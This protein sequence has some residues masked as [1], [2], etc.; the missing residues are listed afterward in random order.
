M[1]IIITDKFQLRQ[2]NFLDDR[3]GIAS[4]VSA[5]KSWNY[6]TVP[7]PE[8]FEVYVGGV[9][10]VYRSSHTDDPVTGKFRTRTDSDGVDDLK[11]RVTRL[12]FEDGRDVASTFAQIKTEAFWTDSTGV[13]HA[14]AGRIVTVT[15]DGAN[16]GPWYLVASDYTK[17]ENWIKLIGRGDLVT[18]TGGA[19]VSNTSVYTSSKIDATFPKKASSENITAKWTFKEDQ[20]FE[21]DLTT[22]TLHATT[23]TITN[24]SSTTGNISGLT[25]GTANITNGTVTTLKSTTGTITNLNSTT[26]KIT[27]LTSETANIGTGTVTT[28]NSTTGTIT[29]LNSTAGNISNLTSGTANIGTGTITALTSTNSTTASQTVTEGLR[30]NNLQATGE[31][32]LKKVEVGTNGSIKDENGETVARVDRI[33]AEHSELGDL[34]ENIRARM[35]L[36]GI[37]N[38]LKNTSFAGQYE[39]LDLSLSEDTDVSGDTVVFNSKYNDW[40]IIEPGTYIVDDADSVTGHSMRLETST[41]SISQETVMTLNEGASYIISW[42]QKGT[43][44]VEVGEYEL[45]IKTLLTTPRY[46][47]CYAQITPTATRKELVVFY[48]GP[49]NVFEIKLEEGVIPTSWF[50]SVLDTD[51]LADELYRFEYLRASF[52]DHPEGNDLTIS[53]VF[54]RNQIKLGDIINGQ[55]TDV[56]GGISGIV[57]DG[58]DVMIWSG[59]TFEKANELLTYIENNESYLDNLTSAQLK[60][61]TKSII[62]LNYKSIFTDIYAVGKFKGKHLGED[63]NELCSYPRLTGFLP[64][65]SGKIGFTSGRLNKISGS[66]PTSIDFGGTTINFN[67][68]LCTVPEGQYTIE[69]GSAIEGISQLHLIFHEG[70]LTKISSVK[71]YNSTYYWY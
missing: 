69:T 63:G 7:I 38:F 54:L 68:G 66:Y 53:N 1:A 12:E 19:A 45:D 3:Q 64:S 52:L 47:F 36:I 50:P 31:T 34:D 43:V 46:K 14:R 23:G 33:I 28:L 5:L 65:S 39:S 56:Y 58:N 48:G 41:S 60:D 25:S 61:L 49:G 71:D 18:T 2:K 27:G 11:V 24:L 6:S 42:N 70:Y 4:S 8:G 29:N 30:T 55:I 59:S 21:K 16:N 37:G 62:T 40:A 35:G 44:R 67:A 20:I 26:G 51:P 22:K 15:S 10:Y 9:W 32:K 17:T 13:S 57:S